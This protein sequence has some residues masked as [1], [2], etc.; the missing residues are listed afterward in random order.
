MLR[1]YRPVAG[2][3]VTVTVDGARPPTSTIDTTAQSSEG[4]DVVP[5]GRL[6]L[7]P[8]RHHVRFTLA[9]AGRGGGTLISLDELSLVEGPPADPAPDVVVDN[10]STQGFQ[11][12]SGTWSAATGV[13]GFYGGNYLSHAAGT[14]SSVVR[15]Q[16]A[17][18]GDGRYEVR[19]SYTAFANRASNAPYTV[20]HR[21]GVDT[22]T[23]DQRVLGAPDVH[24]GEWASLGVFSLAAGLA[25][26]ITLS[27]AADGFVIADAVKL[28]RV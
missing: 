26:T 1:Y 24:G 27:D 5:L 25:T 16:P 15:W 13:A 2:G 3:L 22:V 6:R 7:R 20:T 28:V 4:Y 9:G 19:V 12:V 14:G 23:V 21:D 8:G 10:Q 11:V 18:P 17:V